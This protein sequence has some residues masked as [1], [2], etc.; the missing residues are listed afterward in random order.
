L[1]RDDV[2]DCGAAR[3]EYLALGWLFNKGDT[4]GADQVAFADTT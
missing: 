2:A 3:V 4:A 1:K